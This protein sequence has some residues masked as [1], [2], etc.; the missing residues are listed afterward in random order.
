MIIE[1]RVQR[2]QTASILWS[3]DPD[4]RDIF[5]THSHNSPETGIF[6]KKD[7]LKSKEQP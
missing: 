1:K 3:L 7:M 4:K 2:N 6:K 5:S